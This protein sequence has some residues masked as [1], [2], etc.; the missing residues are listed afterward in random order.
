MKTSEQIKNLS[1]ALSKAQSQLAPVHKSTKAYNYKYAALDAVMNSARDAL[2][3]NGLSVAQGI[4]QRGDL[5]ICVSILMH[6]SGEWISTECPVLFK[7]DKKMSDAQA[8]GSAYTYARRYSFQALIGI[9]PEDDDGRSAGQNTRRPRNT[10]SEAS[11]AQRLPPQQYPS[12]QSSKLASIMDW[13]SVP[14]LVGLLK[15][16]ADRVERNSNVEAETILRTARDEVGRRYEAAGGSRSGSFT[17]EQTEAMRSVG[18]LEECEDLVALCTL[19]D[20]L[21]AGA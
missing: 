16:L 9:A 4:E 1:A 7:A 8:F 11:A 17:L 19:A 3:D 18:K 2:N 5:W 10:S 20:L 15:D 14:P 13:K 12:I 21:E 6:S